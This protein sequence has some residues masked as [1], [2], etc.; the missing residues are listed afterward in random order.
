MD[1]PVESHSNPTDEVRHQLLLESLIRQGRAEDYEYIVKLLSPPANITDFAPPGC[2]KG[3]KIGILG[4][5]L[6]G[7]TA[8]FEL[9]KMGADIT[10]LEA[11][12]ERIGGRIYT[13]YF[14]SNSRY[15]TEFGA[16]RVPVSHETSWYYINLFQLDTFAITSLNSNPFRYV[17]NTRLRST[18]SIETYLYPLYDLST[19]ERV[20]PWTEISNYAYQYAMRLLSPEQRAEMLQVLPQY[21]DD[22]LS[23]I[24]TSLRTFLQELGLSQGVLN[25]MYGLNP[26]AGALY[27]ISFD[28]SITDNYTVDFLNFYRIKDGFIHLPL[29]FLNSFQDS[30]PVQYH[31]TF[32]NQLGNVSYK[33]G[34]LV[35]GIYQ[36]ANHNKIQVKYIR[37]GDARES[38]ELF[39]YVIC[40]IP[41]S[42]LRD[43][44]IKPYLTNQKMQAIYEYNYIDSLK[45][46]FL[47]KERF[48]ERNTYY[49]NING[50]IS[51]TDLPV[52]IIVYPAD[53]VY[54][55][56]N[57]EQLAKESGVLLASYSLGNEAI[58]TGNLKD[59]RRYQVI[60]EN[61][62]EVHGL[63]KGYLNYIV[64][65]FK[66]VHWNREPNFRGAFAMGLPGQKKRF[67]YAMVQ[68]EFQDRLFFA[69]EHIS[70][71]HGWMQGALSTGKEVANQ[72]VISF[73]TR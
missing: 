32:L 15:Y 12:E 21:S 67:A 14:N 38:N 22:Y 17:H 65:E 4:G 33:P 19:Q 44:E 23:M 35:T 6:A 69:G 49:G 55:K 13:Y 63:P 24:N 7:L 73:I 10:I 59:W 8:A 28:E 62:E 39:D 46:A 20:T 2:M 18:D 52:R 1:K 3:V 56:E 51:I 36:P 71:K 70:T 61:V 11:E 9:R 41:F 42:A 25:L 64:Q 68:P 30:E 60:R 37:F 53:H 45:S 57:Q 47:C 72:V 27:P 16:M 54:A 50:G 5:G 29:A 48:W 40:T 34:H 31:G 26:I 58:R 43:V 66:T